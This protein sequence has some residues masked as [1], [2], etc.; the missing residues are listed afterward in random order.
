MRY[1]YLGVCLSPPPPTP[2]PFPPYHFLLSFFTAFTS[3]S[4]FLLRLP[5]FLRFSPFILFSLFFWGGEKNNS[6]IFSF[7]FFLHHF[8]FSFFFF[9]SFVP[10]CHLQPCARDLRLL[11]RSRV[12]KGGGSPTKKTK[13][14]EKRR[15]A[16]GCEEGR[17]THTPVAANKFKSEG[18]GVAVGKVKYSSSHFSSSSSFFFFCSRPA[19]ARWRCDASTQKR[20]PVRGGGTPLTKH[21]GRGGNE[22]VQAASVCLPVCLC[23]NKRKE[24]MRDHTTPSTPPP[25]QKTTTTTGMRPQKQK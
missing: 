25:F 17:E 18:G 16:G 1:A 20:T 21:A 22:K 12:P 10:S 23:R 13:T 11:P 3:P 8:F 15:E 19:A 2:L 14:K 5:L 9:L 6:F 24:D 4:F 7:N